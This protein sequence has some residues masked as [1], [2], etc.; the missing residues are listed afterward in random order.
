MD[1]ITIT[2]LRTIGRSAKKRARLE[3]DKVLLRLELVRLR[4]RQ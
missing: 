2:N 1:I 3:A 4:R